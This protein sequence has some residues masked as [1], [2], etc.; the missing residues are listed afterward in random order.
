MSKRGKKEIIS[1]LNRKAVIETEV[2][3]EGKENTGLLKIL[4]F[5]A[6]SIKNK[7]EEIRLMVIDKKTRYYSDCRKLVV[8]GYLE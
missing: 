4:Y 6:R 1:R 5:N 7:M 3:L 8:R 2:T